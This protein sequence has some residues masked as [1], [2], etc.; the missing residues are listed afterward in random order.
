MLQGLSG[1]L[2]H[3]EEEEEEEDPGQRPK[4]TSG[5]FD[6]Q[7]REGVDISII[8]T[9]S[10]LITSISKNVDANG[11]GTHGAGTIASRAYGVAK[12]ANVKVVADEFRKTGK[13]AHK[14]SVANMSLGGGKSKGFGAVNRAVD[15]GFA[16]AAARWCTVTPGDERASFSNHN[17]CVDV[18]APGLNVR[19]TYICGET[20][21][22]TSMASPH[23]AGLLAYLLTLY[24]SVRFDPDV[25]PDFS[26][27]R[28]SSKLFED[29]ILLARGTQAGE[30]GFALDVRPQ[31]PS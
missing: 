14:G 18:F 13:T 26:S 23:T 9:E 19:S 8:I 7:G 6:S 30:E 2:R 4:L 16:V 21:S 29:R 17:P 10:M 1:R 11:H 25:V 22:G 20:L 31:P 28:N 24:P 5:T 3:E 12:E 15:R 27:I